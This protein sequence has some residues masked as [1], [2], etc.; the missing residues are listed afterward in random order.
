M[1]KTNF[2]LGCHDTISKIQTGFS[3]FYP[4]LDIHFFS[5]NEKTQP[6]NAWI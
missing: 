5:N 2:Y 6:D 4:S 1:K 3:H